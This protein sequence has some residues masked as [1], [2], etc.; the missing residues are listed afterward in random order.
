MFL[1]IL[2]NSPLSDASFANTSPQSGAYLNFLT[3]SFTQQKFIILVTS[4]SSIISFMDLIFDVASKT[5]ITVCKAKL[6]S[7]RGCR[8]SL[9]CKFMIH[10]ELIFVK[11][12]CWLDLC[13]EVI[14][15]LCIWVSISVSL[16]EDSVSAPF[17][18]LCY[19]CQRPV[20]YIYVSPFL[21]SLF[22]S[23]VLLVYFFAHTIPP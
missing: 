23:I 4:V 16:V 5:I 6:V 8:C 11:G 18:C 14:C 21:D 22:Y 10:F 1:S 20:D 13:P 2:G 15:F 3:L 19:F 7:S 9:L 17:Y 12:V